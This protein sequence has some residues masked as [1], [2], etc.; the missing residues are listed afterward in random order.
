MDVMARLT[1]KGQI[2][3][4][5][6]VREALSLKEG[7]QVLF[8]VEEGRASLAKTPDLLD[9]AGAVPV[10]PGKRGMSWDAILEE[11]YRG[12]TRDRR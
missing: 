8:R 2:T 1:S 5:K 3:V 4:P 6:P 9:M 10:P 7:D 11:A 12:A